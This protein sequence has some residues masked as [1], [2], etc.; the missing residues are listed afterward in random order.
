[1]TEQEIK[2]YKLCSPDFEAKTQVEAAGILDI[3]Q[4]RV[5]Q[6]LRKIYRE[7]PTLIPTKIKH[8]K[9]IR[10]EEYLSDKVIHKF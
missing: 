3:S 2:I 10:F 4:Q 8:P 6:I 1:M 5:S 7:H 9:T